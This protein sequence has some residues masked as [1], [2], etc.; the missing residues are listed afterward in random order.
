MQ[1]LVAFDAEAFTNGSE[2]L[3]LFDGVDAEVGFEVQ[4]E[5]EKFGGVAGHLRDDRDDRIG[6][7]V[8]DRCCGSRSRSRSGSSRCRCCG[9]GLV[10]YPADDMRQGG[11]VAQ[12]QVLVALDAEAFAHGGEDFG[13]FD[14]VD[15]E[16]SLEIQVNVKQLRRITSHLGDD[17]DH[18]L[19]HRVGGR[20]DRLRCWCGCRCGGG[21]DHRC[22][23]DGRFGRCL[24]SRGG[25]V[26][27]PQ[28]PVVHLEDRV[29]AAGGSGQP[30]LPG[31]RIDDPVGVAEFTG[32]TP[33]TVGHG[34]PAQQG[35]R[36]LR[37]E[38]GRQP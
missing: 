17:P 11:E 2:D 38:T 20:G 14:G 1:V 21:C 5:V 12:L 26:D 10:P 13:L 3:G 27:D 4:I 29:G 16:V 34:R 33:A 28:P 31:G 18:V 35:H 30:A 24:R 36:D 23:L 15:A 9:A 37:A 7:V 6:H 22:C 8:P 25:T 32:R 19:G